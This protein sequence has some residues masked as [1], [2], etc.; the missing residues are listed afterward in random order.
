MEIQ[1]SDI[2]L[3]CHLEC[4]ASTRTAC[5]VNCTTLLT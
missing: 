1:F 3:V 2:F 5:D 4:D